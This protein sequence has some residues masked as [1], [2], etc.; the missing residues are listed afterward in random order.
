M[1]PA[2][3]LALA[4]PAILATACTACAPAAPP[5][6]SPPAD[7]PSNGGAGP[8]D[9]HEAHDGDVPALTEIGPESTATAN[10]PPL[11]P[12]PARITV[13]PLVADEA[14]TS[15]CPLGVVAPSPA[16]PAPTAK[17]HKKQ[18]S[19]HEPRPFHAAPRIMIDVDGAPDTP[20][21]AEMQ[22]T[23]RAKGYW[24][25]RHC[26]ESGLRRDQHLRGSVAVVL[27]VDPSG[28]V[29]AA[30]A[31]AKANPL[32]DPVAAA[33]VV[34]EVGL[35]SLDAPQSAAARGASDAGAAGPAEAVQTRIDVTLGT[36]DAPVFAAAPIANAEAVR[37]ALR[38]SWPEA[39]RCYAHVLESNPRAGGRMDLHFRVAKDG[40]VT[41]VQEGEAHLAAADLASCVLDV[42]RHATLPVASRPRETAPDTALVYGLELEPGSAN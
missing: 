6:H 22:R 25:V 23:A 10:L 37:E 42:Y 5:L 11:P 15:F 27:S 26:Y 18:R 4:V 17:G 36:G 2:K 16:A 1:K 39:T 40:H 14:P 33:C 13:E 31:P 24:P 9:G 8:Q 19:E 20:A 32:A 38:Q 12:P 28:A 35:L 3:A 21:L 30:P 34:R 7:T 29:T 41:S